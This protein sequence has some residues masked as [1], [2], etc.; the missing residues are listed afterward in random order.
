[1]RKPLFA[2]LMSLLLLPSA[3]V[4]ADPG[5][6]CEASKLGTAAK[7]ASCRLS[8]DS[9]AAKAGTPADYSR[10]SLDRFTLAEY[11]ASLGVCPTEGDQATVK[12]H[13][14]DCTTKAALWLSGG[15][16]LPDPCGGGGGVGVPQTWQT[17]SYGTGSDGDLKRG[18]ARSFTD[19][20]DGTI[21]D[22][23]TGLM[24][25]KKSDNGDIHD[26]DNT[27][28][29]GM[30]TSPYTMNG[31]MVTTFLASLNSGAGFAGYT[32]WRVPNLNE[33]ET[34]KNLEAYGPATFDAFNTGCTAGASVTSGS[35]TRSDF[36]WSSTTRQDRPDLAWVVDFYDG[37][38]H[39]YYKT[40]SYA[41]RAVRAGS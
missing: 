9:K 38:V 39:Y 6:T 23:V 3:G 8:A 21:T 16:G 5:P 35:C 40:Y 13:L 12:N 31:T 19:N 34:L 33:L 15:G 41:V 27:Y 28:T 25:E 1:M 14:D 7:Y 24:W 26:K 18:V 37:Y 2:A 4:A 30:D 32:D 17:T 11:K 36:Y 22:N 20:G 29:W 10:C